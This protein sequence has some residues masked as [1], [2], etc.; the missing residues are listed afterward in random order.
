LLSAY[1]GDTLADQL[2]TPTQVKNRLQNAA[3]GVT[4]STTDTTTIGELIDQVSDFIQHYTGRK[5]VPV[6]STTYIVDTQA[7]YVLRFPIGVRTISALGIA[8]THQPDTGG[9]YTSVAAATILLR[10]SGPD[11]PVGWPATEIRLSRAT[12]SVFSTAEN[13]ASV[14]GTFGFAATPPDITAVTI[15]AVVA[16]FQNRK[17]GTSGVIGEDGTAIVPWSSFF[18]RG[19]PQRATLERYRYMAIG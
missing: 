4:F 14:T 18:T 15:D 19:S 3:A 1:C 5:L 16:A 13:G 9:V 6:T 12:A 11:L 7:G 8:S 10:P 2:C 17:L